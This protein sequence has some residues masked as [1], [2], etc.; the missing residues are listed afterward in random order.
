V[1]SE[2]PPADPAVTG[3]DANTVQTPNL[4]KQDAALRAELLRVHGYEV[5]LD[6]TDEAGAP[7]R[8]TFR[9]RTVVS[10][11]ATAPGTSTFVDVIADRFHEV[12]LNGRPV[13]VSGY[14][15]EEGIVLPELAEHNTLIVDADLLYTTIGQGLHRFVDPIDGEVYLYSQFET[16]DAKRM[17]ACFDQPDLKATFTLHVT[18]PDH[19]QV[20]SNGARE[21]VTEASQHGRAKTV[22]FA[23]TERIS[24]YLTAL[25]AGNYFEA[26][27]HHDGID[28]GLYCRRSLAE[29]FDTDEVFAVTKQGFDWY[30]ANFGVRYAFGKYDQLFVPEYNA[31]AMENVG[32]VTFLEDYVFRSRVTD[33]RYERRAATVLHEM[34]HMWFGD[35]VTMKWFDDLWLNESFAEWAAAICQSE[36]TR[37]PEAWTTFANV[38]K[39]WAYRQDQLPSTHP[40]ACDIPDAE[41]VEVNF[42]GITYAKGAAVLKQLVAYVGREEFLA[43][44][45][46]YFADHAF[47]NTTLADLLSS[48]RVA[49]GRE[50]SDW[51]KAWL[52][53]SGLN[54]IA[55]EYTV[56][57]SGNFA[58]FELV[59]S[60]PTEVAHD[61]VLR[62]HRLAVG[63]YNFDGNISP[64]Y[65]RGRL[66]RVHQVQL[67]LDGE[68]TP[69]TGLIG[70]PKPDLVLANDDDLTYCKLR[71][72][73]DSLRTMRTG[74]LAA[75]ADTLARTMCWTAAWDMLRDGELA[76]RDYLELATSSGPLET[77]IGVVQAVNRQALRALE[78]YA[79]PQWAVGGRQEFAGAVIAAARSAEPASDHQLAWVH[80][81]AAAACTQDQTDFL[82][83]LLAGD[84]V[85]PGLALDEDLRWLLLQAL[86]A[87]G[88]AGEAEIAAM[89]ET[90]RAAAGVRAAATARA[91]IP[92]AEAKL[93]TW[94][95]ATTDVSLSN[96]AM[97]AV[98][99][100]FAHPLQAELIAPF[101]TRYFEQVA[102]IWQQRTPETASDL[103]V[104]LF[105]SWGSAISEDTVAQADAFLTDR[106]QPAALRRLVSEG[107][108]DVVRALHARSV[109]VARGADLAP[110]SI[111]Q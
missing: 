102:Q 43:G 32:C 80:A 83:A 70:L 16:T 51:A 59:Q 82:A 7:S 4:T 45:R 6:L 99:A 67:D 13:D 88:R 97:R 50:L 57:D 100:G 78:I 69:V 8:R 28:L 31:G 54:T 62:P 68:R 55:P 26:R 42:D 105:P 23:T 49:S 73:P 72:D 9:S 46:Q 81:A 107:R 89:A 109:D 65:P 77:S 30:H 11:D 38:E 19:W 63:L 84:E 14:E 44:L 86:V 96:A 66:V 12:S 104:G 41:A 15:P 61:N 3:L 1:A 64:D 24:T 52:E 74:G 111:G 98:V 92:T 36:A 110:D 25:V 21:S 75:I 85:L 29:H 18:A 103:I 95:A 91:L 90:D 106:S 79:D 2:Q 48:L 27:D 58:S 94:H 35:L 5:S 101:A 10:F 93:A 87:R 47:G 60:A 76:A 34:A 17:Y 40:I 56:D 39:T 33:S 20:I 22:H 108:A 71:L 37:W 53:T